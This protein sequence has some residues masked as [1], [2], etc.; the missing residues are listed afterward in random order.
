MVSVSNR[1]LK[2]FLLETWLDRLALFAPRL[3]TAL[4][5][6]GASQRIIAS[7]RWA[8][9]SR[10]ATPRSYDTG[11]QN[12]IELCS[13]ISA[14]SGRPLAELISY[15]NEILNDSEMAEHVKRTV[16]DV[17]ERWSHDDNFRLGRRLSNYL[18]VRSLRPRLVVEAGVDRGLGALIICR[19]L[20]RNAQDGAPGDYLGI[21]HNQDRDPF[22]Y[23]RYAKK[24][25]HIVYGDSAEILSEFRQSPDLII[26]DTNTNMDHVRHQ[27]SGILKCANDRTVI[28]SSWVLS[29]FLGMALHLGWSFLTHQDKALNHWYD[30]SRIMFVFRRP[31]DSGDQGDAVCQETVE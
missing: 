16:R 18:L 26:H 25:G 31:R 7:F 28:I 11:R 1:R 22:L 13:T 17:P 5:R 30:G 14:V 21:E 23:S 9:L 10:D 8:L 2:A 20:E 6:S 12:Q 15:A 24:T 19:A 3:C 4:F 27:V 29:P